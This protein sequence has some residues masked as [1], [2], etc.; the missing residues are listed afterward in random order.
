MTVYLGNGREAAGSVG[1]TAEE[2]IGFN[3][4]RL[5][6]AEHPWFAA[7]L[8]VSQTSDKQLVACTQQHHLMENRQVV[9]S[10][11][12][13]EYRADPTFAADK[14]AD[15][16]QPGPRPTDNLLTF[17]E[18]V[19]YEPPKHKWGMVI[20]LN[21]V[22]RLQCLRGR[23]PSGKQHPHCWQG[24]GGGRSRDALAANRPLHKRPRQRA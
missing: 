16:N 7:G 8:R 6:T 5:R 3:A 14:N 23:L 17:Y 19:D 15:D 18:P 20:D 11:T 10:G 2:T 1:G 12:L 24:A 21:T 4:Y 13:D 22:Y 9:R